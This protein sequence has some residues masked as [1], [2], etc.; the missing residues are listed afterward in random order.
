[1]EN[2]QK[3]SLDKTLDMYF[4]LDGPTDPDHWPGNPPLIA[5]HEITETIN[6]DIVVVGGGH[7]GL[8]CALAAV[9]CGARVT[10][11]E[12]KHQDKMTWVGEQIGTF[13]SRFLTERGFGGYDEDEIIEEFCKCGNYYVHRELIAKYV[14]NSGEALD[15]VLSLVPQD[16]T[17][18]H[19][20]QCNVHC[21]LQ[22]T[23]YPIVR[24]GYKT[25]AGTLQF[26]GPLITTYG[27]RYR[28]NQFSRLPELLRYALQESQRLGADWRFGHSI[29]MLVTEGGRVTGVIAKNSSAK[30]VKFLAS[31]GVAL[32]LGTFTDRGHRLGVWA[33]GHMDNTPFER[34]SRG[35]TNPSFAF[36]IAGFLQLNN[37][38][39]RFF[40]ECVPYGNAYSLQ[41]TG[42]LSW[43]SDSKWL[44]NVKRSG[45]QHGNADFGMPAFIEQCQEDMSHVIEYG[46]K[47]Y[48][49]RNC[50]L[51][52]RETQRVYGANTLEDLAG[53]LGYKGKQKDNFL[54]S[55]E[56]YNELCVKKHDD[57]FG[58]DVDMLY[59]IDS[60]PYYGGYMINSPCDWIPKPRYAG[61]LAGLHTDND[62]C[63]VDKDRNPIVGLYAAGNNLGYLRSV[64][65]A[66]PC[67]GNFIGMAMTHG[68]LLGKHLA[69]K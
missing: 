28:V 33:G 43:V 25:W 53:F 5:A 19:S 42:I 21:S 50:G 11:I 56:R 29:E 17:L 1:L 35:W 16:S 13:N 31:K 46:V 14:H 48:N 62:M 7:A 2:D 49:V 27:V 51:T 44:E 23:K 55:I 60:P 41:P 36:G 34:I 45:L 4:D 39:R 20:D 9:E 40:N 26:R 64:F 12:K 54:N 47:G 69:L 68:R 3:E 57:D 18:L 38:G 15:H 8:H 63:V 22:G 67:G 65:Y 37:D 66:T 61:E 59:P 32:C 58:K 24:G 52:E 6:T 30:Y 10:L